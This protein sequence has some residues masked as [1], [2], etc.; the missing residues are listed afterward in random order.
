MGWRVAKQPNERT[1][2]RAT[3]RRGETAKKT[4]EITKRP[5][6]SV[7]RSLCVHRSRE[8]STICP[9]Y[10]KPK[11]HRRWKRSTWNRPRKAT[12]IQRHL[13]SRPSCGLSFFFPSPCCCAMENV[14]EGEKRKTDKG[15]RYWDRGDCRASWMWL[16]GQ[17]NLPMCVICWV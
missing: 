2:E 13:A 17:S 3:E 16:K 9:Q 1:I 8:L 5:P 10:G 4:N 14:R 7:R 12:A 11:P 15:L 6:S